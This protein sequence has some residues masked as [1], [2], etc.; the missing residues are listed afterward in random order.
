MSRLRPLDIG[1][2][3]TMGLLAVAGCTGSSGDA[4]DGLPSPGEALS[5]VEERLIEAPMSRID[6]TIRSEGAVAVDLAG[7][8]VLGDSGKARL[9]GVGRFGEDDVD[10]LMVSDGQRM[11]VTNGVDT[12]EAATPAALREALVLGLTRMGVLHNLARLVSATPPDHAEGGAG[13]W[14]KA[15]EP[16]R[17]ERGNLAFDIEVDGAVRGSAILFLAPGTELPGERRQTVQFPEG[18]MS[19]T[20]LYGAVSV[21]GGAEPNDFVLD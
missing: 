9:T 15:V 16:R 1:A 3:V 4:S 20:E 17:E 18:E 6:F 13:S 19:V 11:R 21:G 14:V 5:S 10:L 8:L 2:A 12:L 7:S